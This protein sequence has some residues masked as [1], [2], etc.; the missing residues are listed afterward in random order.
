MAAYL[1]V[2]M[3]RENKRR[4]AILADAKGDD[5]L[6]TEEERLRLGD[7][8]IHYRYQLLQSEI[9]SWTISSVRWTTELMGATTEL[10]S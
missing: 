8:S 7:R 2:M 3:A 1:W 4:D 10:G 9:N 5:L 6:E